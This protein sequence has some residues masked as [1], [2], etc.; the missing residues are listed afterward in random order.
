[1]T[2][3]E[4]GMFDYREIKSKIKIGNSQTMTA[5][6]IGKNRVHVVNHNGSVI[7]F[8]WEELSLLWICG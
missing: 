5:I 3:D 1:M 4:T 8:V 7:E 6:K 2:F